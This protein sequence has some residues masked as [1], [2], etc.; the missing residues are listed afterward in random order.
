MTDAPNNAMFSIPAC[1]AGHG[2][3]KTK[4]SAARKLELFLRTPLPQNQNIA[5]NRFAFPN[6]NTL[7]MFRQYFLW[8]F[9][10]QF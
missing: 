2:L 7:N 10:G 3:M 1:S 4:C 5:Y 8:K 9:G 6:K